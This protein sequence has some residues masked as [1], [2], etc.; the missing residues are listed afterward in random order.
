MAEKEAE[1]G[2]RDRERER[3][4]GKAKGRRGGRRHETKQQRHWLA[5]GLRKY[6]RMTGGPGLTAAA[7]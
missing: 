4:K 6:L 1:G 3:G 2:G 7:T 5:S